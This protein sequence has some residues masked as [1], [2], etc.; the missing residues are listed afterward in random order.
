MFQPCFIN[1][2]TLDAAYFKLLYELYEKGDRIE[3][4]SGSNK[5]GERYEFAQ[6]SGIIQNPHECQPL[7]PIMPRGIRPVTTDDNIAKY[8]AE[9]LMNPKLGPNEH[10]RY[11][12]WINGTDYYNEYKYANI[13]NPQGRA[14]CPN[15]MSPIEWV[16]NH[17]RTHGYGN[18]HCFINVGNSDS[19]FAYDI[20][21]ENESERKTSPCLRGISFKIKKDSKGIQR[22][23]LSVV[24]RSWDLYAGFPENMGGFA[25][26][27][28]YVADQLEGVA[29][30]PLMFFSDGLHCYDYQI[31]S[32][33]DA[34]NKNKDEWENKWGK[35]KRNDT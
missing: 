2:N 22:L 10:Y 31:L 4:T 24:F 18:N 35:I 32:V 7:A 29:F 11:A 6:A 34:I 5:G 30:G 27:N 17:F 16:I 26:L 21:Y 25:L 33:I 14:L 12:Q 23:I 20:P 3:I 19:G 13:H 15:S 1:E 9:Y 28:Q 8:F